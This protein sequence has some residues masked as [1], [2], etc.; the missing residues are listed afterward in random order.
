MSMI[1]VNNSDSGALQNPLFTRR[2]AVIRLA[3]L[4][5]LLLANVSMVSR[6]RAANCYYCYPDGCRPYFSSNG[7]KCC[8]G[9]PGEPCDFCCPEKGCETYGC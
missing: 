8:E 2:S 3:L 7:W 9:G 1:D 6:V 4:G 5:A